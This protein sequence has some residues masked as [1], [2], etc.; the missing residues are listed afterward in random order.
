MRWGLSILG[1]AGLALAGFCSEQPSDLAVLP[2]AE[3]FSQGAGCNPSKQDLKLAKK[4]FDKG[5]KLQ[6]AKR[7][8]EDVG[9]DPGVPVRR[10]GGAGEGGI[11]PTRSVLVRHATPKGLA[12]YVRL[13]SRNQIVVQ[14]R[15]R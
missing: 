9:G 14:I 4:A 5:M 7:T 1:V 12:G 15:S 11:L 10:P 8:D 6:S 2:C 13:T 3:A